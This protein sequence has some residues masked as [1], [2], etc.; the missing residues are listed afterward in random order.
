MFIQ[1]LENP[2]EQEYTITGQSEPVFGR[3]CLLGI[4]LMSRMRTLDVTFYCPG[5]HDTYRHI[6]GLFT[7]IVNGQL[8][9]THKGGNHE[10]HQ[11]SCIDRRTW[12]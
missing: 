7:Q 8:I 12:S 11:T 9:Q 5:E 2:Q 10:H 3:A 6:D 4:K 1:T